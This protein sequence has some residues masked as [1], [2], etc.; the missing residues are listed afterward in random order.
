MFFDVALSGSGRQS[1]SSCH[2]PSH[3]F[4]PGDSAPVQLGGSELHLQGL[5]SVPSLTYRERTPPFSVGSDTKSDSDDHNSTA[6]IATEPHS[7]AMLPSAAKL[8]ATAKTDRS[9]NPNP[10]TE[11]LVPRGGMDWDGRAA[12]LSEQAGGP[13]L[14][15]NEMANKSREDLLVKLKKSPY[16][17]QMIQLFG[18]GV[19]SSSNLALGE[20]YFA[21]ARYQ[22]EERSF[23]RYDSK[24]DYYLAR[25]AQLNAQELRGRELFADP[26]KGNCASCHL[27]QPSKDGRLA[28]L[29]TDFQYE[30][31]GAPRNAQINANRDPR[32]FD[33]GLCGPTRKDLTKRAEYCALFKTPSLRN[34]ATRRVFFH[35]GVFRTLQDAVRFYVERETSPEKWYPRL[36]DGKIDMYNDI[37][38]ANRVNV[39]VVDAPFNRKRGQ[40]PALNETEIED[41]VA[42]LGTLTDGYQPSSGP[43]P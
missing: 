43:P 18:P 32:F 30:A 14:D 21:L 4:A 28:P 25:R 42:F 23:H 2:D 27:D 24:F 22:L 5:R 39:D 1:C 10:A 41:V 11:A 36:A 31:L 40:E 20:A 17:T 12:M 38:P 37:R 9:A 29:F 34:V 13:L 8:A 15:P 16:A 3:A 19:F 26:K 7:N 6:A 35:N 33:Q